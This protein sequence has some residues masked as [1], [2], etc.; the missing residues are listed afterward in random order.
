MKIGSKL[1][2]LLAGGLLL[3]SFSLASKPKIELTTID[4]KSDK[5]T[6]HFN[7]D[8]RLYTG[9]NIYVLRIGNKSFKHYSETIKDRKTELTYNLSPEEYNALNSGDVIWI[10]YGE[11]IRTNQ[12]DASKIEK[13]SQSSNTIWYLGTLTK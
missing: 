11:Q 1:I 7:A 8:G 10:S 12:L 4:I 5:V 3:L 2:M 9:N 6:L 13:L